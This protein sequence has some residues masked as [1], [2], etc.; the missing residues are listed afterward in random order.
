MLQ[1]RKVKLNGFSH[2]L[3]N[4]WY[5]TVWGSTPL[6]SVWFYYKIIMLVIMPLESGVNYIIC[7]LEKKI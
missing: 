2:C 1:K 3:E 4:S 7:H 6:P 5:L